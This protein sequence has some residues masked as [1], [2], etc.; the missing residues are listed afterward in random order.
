MSTAA[1]A[2]EYQANVGQD[3]CTPCELSEWAAQEAAGREAEA[4]RW[5]REGRREIYFMLDLSDY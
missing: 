4:D 1:A 3:I 2:N 5:E